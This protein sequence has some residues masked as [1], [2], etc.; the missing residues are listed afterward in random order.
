MNDVLLPLC[1]RYGANFQTGLGFLSI[2]AVQGLIDRT[3]RAGKPCRVLYIADY[4]P[5]GSFMPRQIARQIEF[6]LHAEGLE[7]DIALEPI[8]LS[9]EQVE[10]YQLPRIPIKDTDKRAANFAAKYGDGGA[11][12]L[13]ALEALHPG[14]LREIVKTAMGQFLDLE[15]P[16]RLYDVGAEAQ[17]WLDHEWQAITETERTRLAELRAEVDTLAERYRE[18]MT[19]LSEALALEVEPLRVELEGLWQAITDAA[20]ALEAGLPARPEPDVTPEDT[21]WLFKSERSYLEQLGYYQAIGG[22]HEQ[23]A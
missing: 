13:D 15:L 5:A 14:S 18:R 23:K 3:R 16:G 12:E 22:G 11:V 17:D 20:Q 6:W 8:A 9:R 2:T 7:L 21:Q 1:Q 19:A 4:D 10:R